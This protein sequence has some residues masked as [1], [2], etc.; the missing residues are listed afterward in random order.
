MSAD[1]SVPNITQVEETYSEDPYL[2]G[3]IGYQY[4][5]GLQS[6]NA[7]AQVKHYAGFSQPEQGINT[8]PVHGG[9]AVP[10]HHVRS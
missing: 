7:S 4:V 2:A 1:L 3:E 9:G 8:A 6:L 10:A 5:K